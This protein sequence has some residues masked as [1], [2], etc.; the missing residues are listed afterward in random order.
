MLSC[1]HSPTIRALRDESNR[2]GWE[3]NIKDERDLDTLD[4]NFLPGMLLEIRP[5][6]MQPAENPDVTQEQK[7]T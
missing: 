1:G 3:F 6:V 4:D 7:S 2:R 5:P